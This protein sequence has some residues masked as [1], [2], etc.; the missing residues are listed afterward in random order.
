MTTDFRF[1]CPHE[2]PYVFSVQFLNMIKIEKYAK[3]STQKTEQPF[4]IF[5]GK[6]RG[7]P[8]TIENQDQS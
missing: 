1:M 8:I 4:I 6:V 3:R 5:T 7:A 2:T